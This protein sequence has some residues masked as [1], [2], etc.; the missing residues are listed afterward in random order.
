[1]F[2]E[3]MKNNAPVDVAKAQAA[4]EREGA[5]GMGDDTSAT[6]KD[7]LMR[8]PGVNVHN[9]RNVRWWWWRGNGWWRWGLSRG[10]GWGFLVVLVVAVV[11]SR[12]NHCC[13]SRMRGC[14]R[15]MF[16]TG[17]PHVYPANN[18]LHAEY[19]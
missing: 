1:M 4:G 7:L 19:L 14:K 12:D 6:A 18:N 16:I 8:L 15:A 5:E 13:S 9:F 2:K 10:D 11:A 3:L 17:Q